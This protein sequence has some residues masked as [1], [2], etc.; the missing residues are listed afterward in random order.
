MIKSET[1]AQRFRLRMAVR[2]LKEKSLP[3]AYSEE[4]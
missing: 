3:E 4:D 2:A 1:I